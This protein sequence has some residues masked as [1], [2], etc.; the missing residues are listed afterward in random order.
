MGNFAIPESH[1]LDAFTSCTMKDQLQLCSLALNPASPSP[2]A[3]MVRIADG[4]MES[5]GGLFAIKVPFPAEVGCCFSP[6]AAM[7]FFRKPRKVVAYT[8]NKKK[9]VM[10]EGK[11]K[12]S[13]GCLAAEEMVTLD[14]LGKMTSVSFDTTYLKILTD[15]INP[16][17][18]RI[19]AQGVSFRN[20]VMEATNNVVIIT[21]TTGFSDALEFNL[22][23]ESAKALMKFKSPVVGIAKD[24]NAVKFYFKDGSSLTSLCIAE[25]LVNTGPFYEGPWNPFDLKLKDG[26]KDLLMLSCD[27]LDFRNGD[28]TYI[29]KDVKGTLEDAV[30]IDTEVRVGKES[31]DFLLR[32]GSD[33][34]V[35]GDGVRVMSYSE[36]CRAI[37]SARAKQS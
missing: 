7:N 1:T 10:Q 19:F 16:A 17:N 21:A 27:E 28:I 15:V 35:N 6:N 29:G 32:I 30:S 33:I 24:V 8:V 34:A 36:N 23:Q 14:V 26:V 11:E 22:P 31:F 25:Q 37:C 3:S 9:L 20:G 13:I 2:A 5:F 18:S 12:L 4:Y